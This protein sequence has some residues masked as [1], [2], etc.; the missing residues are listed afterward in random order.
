[1][2]DKHCH[3]LYGIDDG[4]VDLNESIAMLHAAK[5]AGVTGIFATP[6]VLDASFDLKL[7]QERK[8]EIAEHAEEINI[9]ILLGAEVHW[10]ALAR[11]PSETIAQ[12]CLESTN[13]I[14]IEFNLN[15]DLPWDM[16]KRFYALQRM[17]LTVIIAHPERYESVKKKP[18]IAKEWLEMGCKL[19]LDAKFL[20]L[21]PWNQT[22]NSAVAMLKNDMYS[23]YASDAHCAEDYRRFSKAA[24]IIR[25]NFGGMNE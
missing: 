7:A 6:H 13:D 4:A 1:M 21:P 2:L 15:G 12:Y 5:A 23:Y 24:A 11:I 22:R 8:K 14:L 20:L 17:G 3:I 18:E 10:H 25:K 16:I 19:Q 9:R